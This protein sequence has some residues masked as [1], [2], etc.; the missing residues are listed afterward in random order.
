[1]PHSL[2]QNQVCCDRKVVRR[3]RRVKKEKVKLTCLG[4]HEDQLE[5]RL[6]AQLEIRYLRFDV[7]QCSFVIPAFYELGRYHR[8][9]FCLPYRRFQLSVSP[10]N[11][12]RK[13]VLGK[14]LEIYA[15]L[16]CI[17]QLCQRFSTIF[18]MQTF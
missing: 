10:E 6:Y 5:D 17:F 12:G 11:T 7:F 14:L 18:A 2:Y 3:I 15:L 4:P 13:R 1:M 8:Q 9:L 16:P